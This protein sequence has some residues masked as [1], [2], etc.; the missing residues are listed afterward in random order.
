MAQ[1]HHSAGRSTVCHRVRADAAF[2]MA[3]GHRADDCDRRRHGF[4]ENSMAARHY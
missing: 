2:A 4:A 1:R 3:L